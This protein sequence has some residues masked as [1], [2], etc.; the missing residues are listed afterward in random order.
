[1]LHTLQCLDCIPESRV[2]KH[3]DAN[4]Q[5]KHFKQP[6]ST[7]MQRGRHMRG[8]VPGKKPGAMQQR[9]IEVKM[10][11]FKLRTPLKVEMVATPVSHLSLLPRDGLW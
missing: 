2:L 1:M 5:S 3:V 11:K 7:G 6:V 9:N 10:K 4:L 8:A